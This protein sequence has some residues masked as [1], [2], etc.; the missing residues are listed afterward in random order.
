MD[1]NSVMALKLILVCFELC[2]TWCLI[3]VSAVSVLPQA[4]GG[5]LAYQM[6]LVECTWGRN[7]LLQNSNSSQL[8]EWAVCQPLPFHTQQECSRLWRSLYN[9]VRRNLRIWSI[10]CEE[11]L[12]R[13]DCKLWSWVS[14]KISSEL[15]CHSRTIL[16]KVKVEFHLACNIEARLY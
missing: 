14:C 12:L 4:S 10:G 3:L 1:V 16:S 6:L 9:F 8:F 5:Y 15:S 13:R 7:P 2:S 11:A